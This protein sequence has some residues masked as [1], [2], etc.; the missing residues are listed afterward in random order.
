[1]GGEMNK[2]SV[3]IYLWEMLYLSLVVMFYIDL[4]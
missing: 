2:D 4:Y 1:M 3:Q